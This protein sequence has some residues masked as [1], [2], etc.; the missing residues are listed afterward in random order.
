M[1]EFQY[2]PTDFTEDEVIAIAKDVFGSEQTLTRYDIVGVHS[3]MNLLQKVHFA[4][5]QD[6]PNDKLLWDT[7]TII[8]HAKEYKQMLDCVQKQ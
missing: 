3:I 2:S 8:G 5:E 1:K 7:L 4:E 6:T